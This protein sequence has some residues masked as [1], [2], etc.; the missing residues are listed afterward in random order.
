MWSVKFPP[1]KQRLPCPL[2]SLEGIEIRL[3]GVLKATITVRKSRL[4]LT[5]LHAEVDNHAMGKV[6]H[7]HVDFALLGIMIDG[8]PAKYHGSVPMME[9]NTGVRVNTGAFR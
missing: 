9:R 7:F 3:G 8:W 2:A 1:G 4:F 6:A 5:Y